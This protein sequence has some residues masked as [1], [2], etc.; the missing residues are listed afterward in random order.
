MSRKN[1]LKSYV[2]TPV[3]P[4]ILEIWVATTWFAIEVDRTGTT[5]SGIDISGF[6]RSKLIQRE[7]DPRTNSY[8]PTY[9]FS[10]YNNEDGK[11]YF[12]RYYLD[13][14][15]S[16]LPYR[17]QP[18]RIEVPPV[19]AHKVKM[20]MKSSFEPRPMQSEALKFCSVQKY[21]PIA[22][23]PGGGKS[24]AAL[25]TITTLGGPGLI[26]LSMLIPQWYKVIKQF[27]TI[28]NDDIVIAQGFDSLKAIW[29]MLEAHIQPKIVLMSTRTLMMYIKRQ[30]PYTDIP[31]YQEFQK[32]IGFKTKVIDEVHMN[33]WAN[34]IVDVNSNIEHNIYL[35]ATYKRSDY[36]GKLI[37]DTIYPPKMRFGEQFAVKYTTVH[38]TQYG[39]SIPGACIQKFKR[40]QGY[41][42][43]L[44][45]KFLLKNRKYYGAFRDEVII[46][47]IRM[48]W[49]TKKKPG[50]KLLI[51]CQTRDFA[52]KIYQDVAIE[53]RGCKTKRYFAAGKGDETN[54]KNLD[55]EIIVST[56]KSCGTGRDIKNLKTCINT[57][58]FSSDP[59]AEQVMGRLRRIEGEDTIFVDLWNRDIPTHRFHKYSRLEV[60]KKKALSVD[61]IRIN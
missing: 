4:Q 1:K 38:M 23:L 6:V 44:Y 47:L 10:H 34:T 25:Y 28:K 58:S 61:E 24:L 56:I 40:V 13:E 5:K 51:L 37:F 18:K 53:F 39:L 55:A 9:N 57:V 15:I 12:P 48:Y 49:L 22:V 19:E 52:T 54:I 35:S 31:S 33:F 8:V 42:H 3:Q 7:L 60:Y 46:P 14:F 20:S 43:A 30:A 45:E 50:Q 26:V 41:M 36:Y 29:K 17:I 59:L 32:A 27:T 16:C 2:A 21:A 11:A